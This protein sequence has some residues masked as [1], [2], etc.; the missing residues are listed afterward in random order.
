MCVCLTL[1]Q[2]P[3]PRQ[4]WSYSRCACTVW[5]QFQTYRPPLPH[6]LLLLLFLLQ[7]LVLMR[8]ELPDRGWNSTH[9]HTQQIFGVINDRDTWLTVYRKS[10]N[11][12]FCYCK[13]DACRHMY[14]Y[15]KIIWHNSRPLSCRCLCW[16]LPSL[17]PVR[18]PRS[19]TCCQLY[20]QT[21][22]G[23]QTPH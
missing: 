15:L 20:S 10:M 8:S 22:S 17:L 6:P 3:H 5:T 1:T 9:T 4:S 2:T 11:E 23:P 19:D 16:Q 12:C 13:P 14:I 7:S 18:P 21:T